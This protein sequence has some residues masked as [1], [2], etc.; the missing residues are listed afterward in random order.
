MEVGPYGM[1]GNNQ[2]YNMYSFGPIF[3]FIKQFA[4]RTRRTLSE[5]IRCRWRYSC[6]FLMSFYGNYFDFA[7]VVKN[8]NFICPIHTTSGSIRLSIHK[9][10]LISY[11]LQYRSLTTRQNSKFTQVLLLW[12]CNIYRTLHFIT[13]NNESR[14]RRKKT[15]LAHFTPFLLERGFGFRFF[16]GSFVMGKCESRKFVR[17]RKKAIALVTTAN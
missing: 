8:L 4:S 12:V 3:C 14:H 2:L 1:V 17:L 15:L 10:T 11:K 7:R 13:W 9:T 6:L 5:R 16:L